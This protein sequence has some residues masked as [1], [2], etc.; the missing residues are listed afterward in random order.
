MGHTVSVM[1]VD[2]ANWPYDAHGFW[3]PGKNEILLVRQKRSMMLHTFWHEVTH[4]ILDMMSSR[5]SHNEVFVDQFGG[6]L[7]QVVESAR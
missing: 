1:I 2:A 4:A 3:D 7:A 6:L 5:L